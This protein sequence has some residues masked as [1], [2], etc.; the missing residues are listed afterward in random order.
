M[1]EVYLA[2][3]PDLGQVVVKRIL[4]GLTENPRFL[5]LFLD[6]TR[7]AARLSHPNIARIHELGEVG[8]TWYVAMELVQG[9]DLRQLLK[10]TREH[11]GSVPLS[12]AVLIAR[13]IA[14]A[15][16]YAHSLKDASGR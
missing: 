4:P 9:K 14:V 16:S 12:V 5:R 1:G 10:R 3:A 7:I 13:E 15:L 11:G 2:R 8:Q 6:E